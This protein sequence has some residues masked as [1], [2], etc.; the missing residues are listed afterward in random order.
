MYFSRD[1]SIESYINVITLYDG[2]FKFEYI[3]ES[4]ISIESYINVITLY[5]GKFKFEY[6]SESYIS[7][8]S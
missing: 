2:K 6:I 1:L 3:S 5:D 8:E 7:I 4:Y